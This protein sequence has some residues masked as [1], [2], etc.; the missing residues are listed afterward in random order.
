MNYSLDAVWWRLTHPDV[1]ALASLLTA[2][3]LWHT[4][5][6]LPV[7]LLLGEKGFRCLLDWD[8]H[9]EALVAH[10]AQ[11]QPFGY[12]L[13]KYAE[14]LL[15]FWFAHAPH[16]ELLAREVVLKN[17]NG[18]SLGALDFLV[19]L[20][21]LPYHVELTCKYYG[22]QDGSCL[23]QVVG[24]NTQDRLLDKSA[25]LVVQ[26]VNGQHPASMSALAELGIRNEA[27]S[28]VS[29]VRGMLFSDEPHQAVQ[30]VNQGAWLGG[31]VSDWADCPLLPEERRYY[32]IPRMEWL[33]PARVDAQSC[34]SSQ[35]VS[36]VGQGLVAVLEQRPD[37][38]WHETGRLM[39]V[40]G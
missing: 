31:Y 7:R 14:S 4:G 19:R 21:G 36:A 30:P 27:L 34:L 25:K 18:E 23:V 37:G 6:E 15:A 26:L 5:C 38:Y 20:N 32:V 35:Q 11:E 8:E 1:R 2:P 10:L 9:P 39:K 33:A 40:L 22:A 13:G 17:A 29:I 16:S 12:R 28:S 24:V 3:A